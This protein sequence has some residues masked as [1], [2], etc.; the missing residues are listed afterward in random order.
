M[1]LFYACKTAATLSMA[2]Y[3]ESE[4]KCLEFIQDRMSRHNVKAV[5]LSKH[6]PGQVLIAEVLGSRLGGS[7]GSRCEEEEVK[8]AFVAIR[9]STNSED[10]LTNFEANASPSLLLMDGQIHSGYA[11]RAQR[12]VPLAT[13]LTR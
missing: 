3:A 11:K 6:G 1:F 7:S 2:V 9:G 4:D 12:D 13:I 8:A 5:G 10:W